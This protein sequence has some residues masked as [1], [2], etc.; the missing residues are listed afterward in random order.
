[1]LTNADVVQH[2]K[3]GLTVSEMGLVL[4]DRVAFTLTRDFTLK[5]IQWLDVVLEEAEDNGDD[6]QSLAY[7]TQLLMSAALSELLAELVEL[8]GGWQ[9]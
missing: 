4:N 7:A 8:L 5:R 2:A 1:M 9:E 6:A 3:N